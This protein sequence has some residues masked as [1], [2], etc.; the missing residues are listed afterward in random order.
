MY[1]GVPTR[2]EMWCQVFSN[3]HT[4]VIQDQ[5]GGMGLTT[6]LQ[7]IQW[8]SIKHSHFNETLMKN[9]NGYGS[10]SAL[11][12][13]L[14]LKWRC[15]IKEI[16]LWLPKSST[17]NFKDYRITHYVLGFVCTSVYE[18]RS[19]VSPISQERV[20]ERSYDLCGIII[21]HSKVKREIDFR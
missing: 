21:G 19:L 18:S 11:G 10:R 4:R 6:T 8:T 20:L 17:N 12:V 2:K 7:R 16:T 9:F 15:S 5:R 3:D 1:S 13:H 14:L